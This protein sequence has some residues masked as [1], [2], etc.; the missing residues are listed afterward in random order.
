MPAPDPKTTKIAVGVNAIVYADGSVSICAGGHPL[1]ATLRLDADEA[2]RLAGAIL[3]DAADL[4]DA[5]DALTNAAEDH[6]PSPLTDDPEVVAEA[7]DLRDAIR[8]A[9]AVLGAQS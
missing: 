5:L 4:R 7:R 1:Q 3:P 9:R 6:C 8:H 2:A